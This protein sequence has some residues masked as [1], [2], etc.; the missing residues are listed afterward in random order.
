MDLGLEE[1]IIMILN[2]GQSELEVNESELIKS[3]TKSKDITALVYTIPD[4]ALLNNWK[5]ESLPL[6]FK[7]KKFLPI[8]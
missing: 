1:N 6:V 4:N 3:K 7:L 8:W 5:M 2:F